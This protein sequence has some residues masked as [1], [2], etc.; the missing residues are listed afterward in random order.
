MKR[1]CIEKQTYCTIPQ[2]E[3]AIVR[4]YVFG[5]KALG[6]YECPVCLDFHLTS[7]Y[8]SLTKE[9]KKRCVKE[10]LKRWYPHRIATD[11]LIAQRMVEMHRLL[12]PVKRDRKKEKM[13]KKKRRALWEKHGWTKR[14]SVLPLREQQAALKKLHP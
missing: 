1:R 10:Y 14:N 5:L 4:N 8:H 3:N 9:L 13:A 2:A 12:N 11:S 6:Y 7:R